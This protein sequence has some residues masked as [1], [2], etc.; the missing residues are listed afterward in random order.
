MIS[1]VIIINSWNVLDLFF[2]L[3]IW[4]KNLAGIA[5]REKVSWEWREG[6]GLDFSRYLWQGTLW[7]GEV[8]MQFQIAEENLQTLLLFHKVFINCN[9]ICW[10]S[11]RSYLYCLLLIKKIGIKKDSSDWWTVEEVSVKIINTCQKFITW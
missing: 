10:E 6:E 11:F 2:Q 5:L 8:G 3:L 9:N 7:I 1:L 4:L